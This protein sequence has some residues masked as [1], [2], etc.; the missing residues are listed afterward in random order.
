MPLSCMNEVL[1]VSL[2]VAGT[3]D[4]DVYI[5]LA[6]AWSKDNTTSV[7]YYLLPNPMNYL[8]LDSAHN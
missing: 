1:D 8:G 7:V 4:A 6:R 2:H 3:Q 5:R